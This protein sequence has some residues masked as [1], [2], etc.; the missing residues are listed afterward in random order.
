MFEVERIEDWIGVEVVDSDGE[1]VGKLDDVF[2]EAEGEE[3]AI[4]SVK[5]GTFGRKHRLVPLEG[6]T[7]GRDYVRIPHGAE[8]IEEAPELDD[9]ARVSGEHAAAL[10]AHY[11]VQR[12]S[13]GSADYEAASVREERR[14][15][16]E[17]A[18]NRADELEAEAERQGERARSLQEQ[19]EETHGTAQDA[20]QSRQD[21]LAE[22]ERLRRE[23]GER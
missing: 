8:R 2:A 5:A 21:A 9:D 4:A 12:S 3:P 20:D 15:E 14:A 7:L 11:G 18:A 6:A 16:A 17:A 13:S 10:F 1:K 22:A 19:S 23:A